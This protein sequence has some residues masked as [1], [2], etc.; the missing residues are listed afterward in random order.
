L[1]TAEAA[2]LAAIVADL[3][4]DQGFSAAGSGAQTAP[5]PG[6]AAV[7]ISIDTDVQF[8]ASCPEGGTV[9]VAAALTGTVD[10]DLGTIDLSMTVVQTHAACR[11]TEPDSGIQ[12]TLNG[13]PSLSVSMDLVS[14]AQGT[15]STTASF[16]GGVEWDTDGR[17][18]TCTMNLSMTASGNPA[19]QSGSGS[20]SGTVC[21][22][23]INHSVSS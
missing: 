11:A 5:T 15:Y 6:L 18:G 10:P 14:S 23:Q 19:S 7:P 16:T 17:S 4:L 9:G 8:N 2:A 13:S 21:G 1:S 3:A 12:F 22:I 20:V